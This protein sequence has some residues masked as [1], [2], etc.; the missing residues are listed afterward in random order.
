MK[1]DSI[2]KVTSFQSDVSPLEERQNIVFNKPNTKNSLS[3]PIYTPYKPVSNIKMAKKAYDYYLGKGVKSNVAAGIV[4][5][6]YKE[7]GLNPNAVGDKGTS[8]GVA[9]WRG[10]RFTGLKNYATKRGTSHNDLNTQLDYV[11]D[12]Q[13]ENSVISLMGNQSPEQAA[14]TFADKYERPNPQYADYRT[15]QS[16]AKQ[17]SQM[18]HG[19]YI[20]KMPD[21]GKPKNVSKNLDSAYDIPS[22]RSFISINLAKRFKQLGENMGTTDPKLIRKEYNKQ[23]QNIHNTYI[24]N[25]PLELSNRASD[26]VYKDLGKDFDKDKYKYKDE[27]WQ[28]A[29][30]NSTNRRGTYYSGHK[31]ILLNE[32]HKGEKGEGN[33]TALHE[34]THSLEANPQEKKI[35][36]IIPVKDKYY[37]DASEVYSRRME[38][39]K[40]NKINPSKKYTLE[41]IKNIR[42]NSD[43]KD[44]EILN[45]YNDNQIL[46]LI[47]D[48]AIKNN[49][50]ISGLMKAK[51]GGYIARM[52]KGGKPPRKAGESDRDYSIRTTGRPSYENPFKK[53]GSLLGEAKDFLGKTYDK[54]GLLGVVDEVMSAPARGVTKAITGKYQDPSEALDIKN[55]YAKMAVDMVLD[56]TN[57][58]PL[59]SV[60]KGA[61]MLAGMKNAKKIVKAI[62]PSRSKIYKEILDDV[63]QNPNMIKRF[64]NSSKK[65]NKLNLD[66]V[67]N[68]RFY[69][70]GTGSNVI[71]ETTVDVARKMG[72]KDAIKSAIPLVN[73]LINIDKKSNNVSQSIVKSNSNITLNN[74]RIVNNKP[75]RI[76]QTSSTIKKQPQSKDSKIYSI[77]KPV[78][79]NI[80]N[81]TK[82]STVNYNN[83]NLPEEEVY[84]TPTQTINTN[85]SVTK[86]TTSGQQS[87]ELNSDYVKRVSRENIT[88]KKMQ[89]K[90]IRNAYGG[91][92]KK[93]ALG[94]AELVGLVQQGMNL[95]AGFV[96]SFNN[97]E[98][99]NENLSAISGFMKGNAAL[100][101]VG[102]IL[103]AISGIKGARKQ[104][105]LFQKKKNI[106]NRETMDY[107]N[108][109][110]KGILDNY[111]T[112]GVQGSFY[113]KGGGIANP[114]YEVEHNEVIVGD[115]VQLTGGKQ[116]AS[117][118]HKVIGKTHDQFNPNTVNGTGE[119][120]SGGEFVFSDRLGLNGK[121]FAHLATVL[122][123]QKAKFEKDSG[124]NDYVFKNTAQANI[125]IT[126]AKL[127]QLAMIQEAMK[128][129]QS[130]IYK[131]GGS[132]K[133]YSKGGLIGTQKVADYQK[134]LNEKY[135]ANL[136]EDGAWG[137]KTEEAYKKY[138][139]QT[140]VNTPITRTQSNNK[141]NYNINQNT[142]DTL[143]V[144]K[145]K[146]NTMI[147]YEK[148]TPSILDNVKVNIKAKDLPK[149]LGTPE[150]N[151]P[152]PLGKKVD[153]LG[154]KPKTVNDLKQMKSDTEV[155]KETRK[156]E[157]PITKPLANSTTDVRKPTVD[158]YKTKFRKPIIKE[159]KPT[160]ITTWD[161]VKLAIQN[162]QSTWDNIVNQF[163]KGN[164]KSNI[165][166]TGLGIEEKAKQ[167]DNA[168]INKLKKGVEVKRPSFN[169]N[170]ESPNKTPYR[171]KNSY[172]SPFSI[173]LSDDKPER[174]DLVDADTFDKAK[175]HK[176]IKNTKGIVI[177][178]FNKFGD[179]I[180][181]QADVINL[182]PDGSID[183]GKRGSF[184]DGSFS[185]LNKIPIDFSDVDYIY[186]KDDKNYKIYSKKNKNE[187]PIYTSQKRKNLDEATDYGKYLGG[188]HILVSGSKKILVNG[189][190]K[191]FKDIADKLTK[192]TGKPVELYQLDNG[193]Y[194]LPF[195]K[196]D[197]TLNRDDIISHRNR[198]LTSGGVGLALRKNAYGG[199]IKQYKFGGSIPQFGLGS[200]LTAE[201]AYEQ[202]YK[203]LQKTAR[204]RAAKSANQAAKSAADAAYEAAFKTEQEIAKK[205]GKQ[206]TTKVASKLGTAIGEG[207]FQTARIAR[208]GVGVLG[209][210]T[211]MQGDASSTQ[212]RPLE[213]SV[214]PEV[215]KNLKAQG[216]TG[217][218]NGAPFKPTKTRTNQYSGNDPSNIPQRRAERN[219]RL[220]TN[221]PIPTSNKNTASRKNYQKSVIKNNIIPESINVTDANLP[222]GTGIRQQ[223]FTGT[224][225]SNFTDLPQE[226]KPIIGSDKRQGTNID[227]S[228]LASGAMAGLSYLTNNNMINQYKT[229]VSA[230]L[231]QNPNYNY[232]DRSGLARNSVRGVTNTILNN[233]F[234]NQGSKQAAFANSLNVGNQ[235]EQEE[236]N[237]KME[238]DTQYRAASLDTENRNNMILNQARQ[239]TMAN[240]NQ[241]LGMKQEN[242]NQLFQNINTGM[243]EFNAN[244]MQDKAMKYYSL[245]LMKRLGLNPEEEATFNKD[246]YNFMLGRKKMGGKIKSKYC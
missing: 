60:V 105:E 117:N 136:T 177:N 13:G 195:M 46:K 32:N 127:Q 218:Y 103:G 150:K 175:K 229:K 129:K 155:Y 183:I 154:L 196:S 188:K 80:N 2:D 159:Q 34:L 168:S 91:Y 224:V 33:S 96:D 212:K 179:E 63:A 42:N 200:D 25:S 244:K 148:K 119:D 53:V 221:N 204:A 174:F 198:H 17:L 135:G 222:I 69:T 217:T 68:T 122:G 57:L 131:Y 228:L 88:G 134:M 235:I 104:R 111:P 110:S 207:L 56:P 18:K 15:R 237:R 201:Q 78:D 132:I 97:Q 149:E 124:H 112:K 72:T 176:E 208:T 167:I 143:F 37:D 30:I 133:Q 24:T 101:G 189:S 185:R 202:A 61:K 171:T 16:V 76:G 216:F 223:S 51:Y 142:G 209:L 35:S 85:K 81:S 163:D 100:P 59:G 186:D 220:S 58:I 241:K 245:P 203:N 170:Y 50:N 121:S 157:T 234:L 47:N 164:E 211:E 40:A 181:N 5:N 141:G 95:G 187:I 140:D 22:Q 10:N 206:V 146:A 108:I 64:F 1:I 227:G 7:S 192:E 36:T 162:P 86:S 48:V 190:V 20:G 62:D 126:D 14:K 94:G 75:I 145:P 199:Y 3:S 84:T 160:E 205:V 45:R 116:I 55:P 180:D 125:E 214:S 243:S 215:M 43:T 109:R 44:F 8:F 87:Y 242:T 77:K 239:Q 238:Y 138:I 54:D 230:N 152:V 31:T 169:Y 65:W 161:K 123:K 74:N 70:M 193:A 102:G 184:K 99:P 236:A 231:L 38:F 66:K 93:K 12:E 213:K 98:N 172:H 137:N 128:E 52:Q 83:V 67:G 156:I 107:F 118:I 79:L 106:E 6:L 191:D 139:L 144:D 226:E 115:D 41:E 233:P 232:Y 130:S 210:A 92:L 71:A 21:G 29:M 182:K 113:A 82:D 225:D 219:L 73:D 19:G 165:K 11:L 89:P 4:G 158:E 166:S 39:I 178:T 153:Y 49:K 26:Y 27:I 147:R 194:N 197:N 23:I 114:Q 240:E 9:Q 120:G 151:R 90:L 173:D 28:D 246:P